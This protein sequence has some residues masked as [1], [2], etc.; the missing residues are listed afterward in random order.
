MTGPIRGITNVDFTPDKPGFSRLRKGTV[1]YQY[2]S[3]T[4][5]RKDRGVHTVVIDP[6]LMGKDTERWFEI[7]EELVDWDD[8]PD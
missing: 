2:R 6:T 1:V 3:Q 7:P 5:S 8:I 4:V